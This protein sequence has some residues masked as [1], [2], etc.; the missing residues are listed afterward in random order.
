[1]IMHKPIKTI[2]SIGGSDIIDHDLF[3]PFIIGN[4]KQVDHDDV[5]KFK[6]IDHVGNG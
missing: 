2:V 3:K 5:A 1:M 4:D 6:L